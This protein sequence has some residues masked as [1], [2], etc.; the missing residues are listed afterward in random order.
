MLDDLARALRQSHLQDLPR[1]TVYQPEPG[2]DEIDPSQQEYYRRMVRAVLVAQKA[3]LPRL[4]G[5][6]TAAFLEEESIEAILGRVFDE[7]GR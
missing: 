7:M 6:A 1:K 3:L 4:L 5:M 2:F